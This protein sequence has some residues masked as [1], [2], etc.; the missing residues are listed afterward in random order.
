MGVLEEGWAVSPSPF[1]VMLWHVLPTQSEQSVPVQSTCG[2]V[3]QWCWVGF[4]G[5]ACGRAG[6]QVER[7]G[8]GLASSILDVGFFFLS[9]KKIFLSFEN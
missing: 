8:L 6:C 2:A 1:S 7:P 5:R 3:A 9:K 4:G